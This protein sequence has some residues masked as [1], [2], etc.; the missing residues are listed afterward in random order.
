[1]FGREG[2]EGQHVGLGV[3]KQRCDLRQPALELAD[4]V[5]QAPA[6]LF[7]LRGGEIE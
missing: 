5:A 2:E 3:L 7:T 1:V 4:R 6:G